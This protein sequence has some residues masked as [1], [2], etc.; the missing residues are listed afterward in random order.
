MKK[1]ALQR[2]RVKSSSQIVKAFE[3]RANSVNVDSA[4]AA[5]Q[6]SLLKKVVS[7]KHLVDHQFEILKIASFADL[8]SQQRYLL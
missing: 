5:T 3:D 2:R 8:F 1:N 6:L 7:G 4:S